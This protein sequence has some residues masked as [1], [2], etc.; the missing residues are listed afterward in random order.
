[1]R[2]RSPVVLSCMACQVTCWAFGEAAGWEVV[3]RSPVFSHTIE[4]VAMNTKLGMRGENLVACAMGNKV[5]SSS[6]CF[7]SA[8][9][10]FVTRSPLTISHNDS[11]IWSW[12]PVF[13]RG[14]GMWMQIKLWA[15]GETDD[16]P[17]ESITTFA[18]S[19]PVDEL[20]FIGS[21]L[22]ALS[23]TGVVGVR[24]SMTQV[25]IF[26]TPIWPIWP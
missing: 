4:H 9:R 20:L 15:F 22:V 14:P 1:M 3:A 18:L 19:V 23:K 24:N 8:S 12:T 17:E 13:T 16:P 6:S 21:Q 25:T 5:A 2:N 11:Y 26:N 10:L 7:V